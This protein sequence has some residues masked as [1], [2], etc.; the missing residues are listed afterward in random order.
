MAV[1]AQTQL[2][3]TNATEPAPVTSPAMSTQQLLDALREHYIAPHQ[4]GTHP[5]AAFLT[6]VTAPDRQHRADAVH[7][8]LW[9]SRGY[10]VDVHE[11]KTSRADF[12]RELDKPDK[13]E[14]WWPHSNTFWI[15]APNTRVAPPELLPPGW[16]LMVP[17]RGRRFK[18]VVAAEHREFSPSTALLAT[19]IISTQTD[20]A[21]A[22]ER[23]RQ[24]MDTRRY[25]E[26]EEARK[27]G[28]LQGAPRVLSDRLRRLE[29]LEQLIGFKL[30]D[31]DTSDS[32]TVKTL[33]GAIRDAVTER[34][35][36]HELDW[37]LQSLAGDAGRLAKAAEQ[38]RK[39]LLE[40]R[41]G[42]ALLPE[43][44]AA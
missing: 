7:V 25:R 35:V 17:G 26:V 4:R 23:M 2:D 5:G 3:L 39:N 9:A 24:D 37:A 18:A 40:R 1:D 42:V 31:Y 38:A 10:T 20:Q 30:D 13:A 19:L 11:L 22:L 44:G 41:G 28:A 36:A 34:Q 12:Q 33:A 43:A 16:G 32:V 15:V 6:E 27:E 8:G 29:Q 21:N 14:A